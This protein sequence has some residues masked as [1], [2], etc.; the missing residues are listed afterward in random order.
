MTKAQREAQ[1]RDRAEA[2][3]A[4]IAR[5]DLGI[6]TLEVRKRDHLDFHEVSVTS[7]KEALVAAYLMGRRE[8]RR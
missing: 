2:L 6:E 8:A 4:Q 5:D 7:L 3:A 1:R